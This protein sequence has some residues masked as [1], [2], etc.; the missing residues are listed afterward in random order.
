MFDAGWIHK[1]EVQRGYFFLMQ[2][3][4]SQCSNKDIKEGGA[5][6][7]MGG[8]LYC[9]NSVLFLKRHKDDIFLCMYKHTLLYLDV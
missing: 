5:T 3:K 2:C 7:F 1:A 8:E 6:L 9:K 4:S